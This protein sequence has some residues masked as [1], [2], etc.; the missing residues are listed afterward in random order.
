MATRIELRYELKP[1]DED[2]PRPPS[3][4]VPVGD[5][6]L[7]DYLDIEL[8]KATIVGGRLEC[9]WHAK[10]AELVVSFWSA[11]P[12]AD[13]VQSGLLKFM[14]AQLEDGIG[15]NGFE[16]TIASERATFDAASYE[17]ASV[18]ITAVD[19]IPY[20]VPQIAMVAFDGEPNQLQEAIRLFP[21]SIDSPFIEGR[22]ALHHSLEKPA[23]V[24][25]LLAA[26]AN[27]N[28]VDIANMT[29][30]NYLMMFGNLP[31]DQSL[32]IVR[33]L[34]AAGAD[35]YIPD[36]KGDTALDNARQTGKSY[37]LAMF[38]LPPKQ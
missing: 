15:E 6:L 12:L 26:G 18:T 19:T 29:P 1:A 32:K 11:K 16:V 34:L 4:R 30:L 24:E 25:I 28:I 27:P 33:L 3:G 14:S 38:E 7:Q 37:A 23:C 9:E 13:Y 36:Y 21:E 31:E 10:A 20:P 5:E 17:P 8:I 22:T 2:K 35:P